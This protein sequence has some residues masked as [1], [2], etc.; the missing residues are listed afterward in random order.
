MTKTSKIITAVLALVLVISISII[1][2][3]YDETYDYITGLVTSRAFILEAQNENCTVAL[4]EGQNVVSFICETGRGVLEVFDNDNFSVIY[5]FD[6]TSSTSPWRIYHKELSNYFPQTLQTIRRNEGYII[7]MNENS[8]YSYDGILS[9]QTSVQLK[10]GWNLVGFPLNAN[11]TTTSA[12]S[13]I[14]SVLIRAETYDD[15]WKVYVPNSIDQIQTLVPMQ[16]YWILVSNDVLWS[17]S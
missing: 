6:K 3:K 5:M 7:I 10:S 1:S 16:G 9:A 4:I 8:N 2:F 13:S 14:S 12:F 17:V 15:T 11:R